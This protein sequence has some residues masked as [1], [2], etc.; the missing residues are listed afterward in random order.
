MAAD[1][2]FDADPWVLNRN[3]AW[4]WY[5]D[6]RALVDPESNVLVVGSVAAPEGEDGATRAGNVELT[7][8]DL[9]TGEST[10]AVLHENLE[11]D[12]HNVPGLWRRRDGRWLAVYAK[13]KSDNYTRWRIS[14]P[15]DPT[16]W[17]PEQV[18]DWTELTGGRGVT[19]SNLH[20]LD[21]RLYCFARAINDDACAL[22]SDD[23]GDT[24][25]FAGKLFDRPKVG[26]VNGYCRYAG[27]DRID[28]LTTDHHPRDYNNSIYH[29]YLSAGA[30][31]ASDGTVVDPHA[32]SGQAP[33]QA[34]LTTVFAAGSVW[35]G[36]RM[37]RG[38]TTDIRRIEGTVVAT[39]TARAND[40]P[41][42][43]NF[44]DHRFFYGR[45]NDDGTWGVYQVAKAGRAL[46]PREEDYTGLIAIDPYDA[47]SVYA[48]THIDPRDG[49]ELAHH[50]IFHG[51]TADGGATWAW[52]PV[53]RDSPVDNLRPIV[54]PGDPG[55]L[56]LLWFR[57]EMTTSQHYACEIAAHV[58]PRR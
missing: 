10:I 3:G 13:H 47:D 58:L 51:R 42:N 55:T 44:A 33:D 57:G 52:T 41:E 46:F 50:E 45:T 40:E 23:E 21:G 9:G 11:A 37:T 1:P 38:W 32:L 53:T 8:T 5:Q 16:T 12:D 7:V 35:D 4:C 29:G 43:S 19:Y 24:W 36:E 27:T 30:L 17:G 28:V 18:F 26:Y 31:H 49:S 34:E 6:E 2:V 14:E 20:E 15:G 25:T 22:V 54:A 56:V 39:F 48:S